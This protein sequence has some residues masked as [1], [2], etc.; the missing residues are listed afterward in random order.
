MQVNMLCPALYDVVPA[1]LPKVAQSVEY[2]SEHSVWAL[3]R[4]SFFFKNDCLGGEL[5]VVL[6]SV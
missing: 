4:S 2:L 6:W 5:H 1:E 3:N